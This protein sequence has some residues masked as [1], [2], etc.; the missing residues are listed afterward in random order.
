MVR[1]GGHEP[2]SA[3]DAEGSEDFEAI[4]ISKLKNI[5]GWKTLSPKGP[6][7]PPKSSKKPKPFRLAGGAPIP[8]YT[9]PYGHAG[10]S[11]RASLG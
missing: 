3:N 9:D 7:F 1:G 6:H 5:D 8:A 2:P 4:D 10:A 11:V